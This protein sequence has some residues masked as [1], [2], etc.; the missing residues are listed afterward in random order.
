MASQMIAE[1]RLLP[2]KISRNNKRPLRL[3]KTSIFYSI[4]VCHESKHHTTCA[5]LRDNQRQHSVTDDT[6]LLQFPASF[7]PANIA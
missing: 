5:L 6:S 4:Q 1:K 7:L 2:I 3:Q